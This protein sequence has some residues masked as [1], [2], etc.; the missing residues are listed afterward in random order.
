MLAV[1][2]GGASLLDSRL[3]CAGVCLRNSVGC[4]A[5][6]RF[7]ARPQP[8]AADDHVGA[9]VTIPIALPP[10]TTAWGLL[11]PLLEAGWEVPIIDDAGPASGRPYIR[12]S[13]HLYNHA[14]EADDLA[15]ELHG[16]GVR[17]R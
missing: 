17:L 7:G 16:R 12:L 8:I 10:G 2:G 5:L 15:R 3:S 9:M 1:V 11:Q 4:D 14:A 13:A 6:A